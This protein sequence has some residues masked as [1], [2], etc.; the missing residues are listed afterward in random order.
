[1]LE[2]PTVGERL[3]R[4]DLV[5]KYPVLKTLPPQTPLLRMLEADDAQSF[6]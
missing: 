2:A 3:D 4:P 6:V 5:A 1:M